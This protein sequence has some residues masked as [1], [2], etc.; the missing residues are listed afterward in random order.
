MFDHAR[1]RIRAVQNRDFTARQTFADQIFCFF[2]DPV[3]FLYIA[4]GFHHAHRFAMPGIGAQI[5][6]ETLAVVRNQ[7]I[8]AIQNMTMRTVILFQLDQVSTANSCSNAVILPT[9]APRKA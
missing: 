3:R 5:F 7:N 8:R 9:F 2:Y 1:L 6:A 4:A